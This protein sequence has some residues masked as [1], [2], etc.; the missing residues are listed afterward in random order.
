M[1]KNTDKIYDKYFFIFIFLIIFCEITAQYLF[2]KPPFKNKIIIYTV[3]AILY[4]IIGIL[5]YQILQY[6]E[7]IVINI[8][9]HLL[10]FIILFFIGYFILGEK[11]S[12]NKTIASILGLISLGIFLLEGHHH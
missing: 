9:W 4:S 12:F 10:H 11:L 5:A 2:K 8:V 6:G 3:G 7:L 1:Y